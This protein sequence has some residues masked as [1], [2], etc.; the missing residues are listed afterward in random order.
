MKILWVTSFREFKGKNN[1]QIQL[2]FLKQI[3]NNNN[4]TLCVTQFGEKNV[5]RNI[6]NNVKSFFYFN[7][8]LKKY[9]YCQNTIFNNGL[10]V[11][12]KKNFSKIVWSTADFTLSKNYQMHLDLIKKNTIATIFPNIHIY[13]NKT[14]DL[15]YPHFG[16]DFFLFSLDKNKIKKLIRYNKSCPNYEW[17]CFEHF[18]FCLNNLLKIKIIN[19]RGKINLFKYDNEENLTN[20]SMASSLNT[21]KKNNDYLKKFLKIYKLNRLYAT[22][23]FYFIAFKLFFNSKISLSILIIYLRLILKFIKHLFF[24]KLFN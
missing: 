18:L 1:D 9:K 10:R 16:L 23:S 3:G 20:Y 8:K 6:Q 4:V 11:C 2:K 12:L 14:I 5:K 24:V 15:T 19:L 7:H 21:W 13:K 17:G 22:G